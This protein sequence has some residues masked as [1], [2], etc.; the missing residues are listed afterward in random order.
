MGES[1][2]IWC[3]V[4]L[5]QSPEAPRLSFSPLSA[6]LPSLSLHLGEHLYGDITAF[7]YSW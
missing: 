6:L 4:A 2:N 5:T 1:E 3:T 7:N